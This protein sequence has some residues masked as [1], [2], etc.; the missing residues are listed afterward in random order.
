M[1][2]PY[3][4][5]SRR[6][7]GPS[8]LL[9]QP[10]AILEVKFPARH[11]KLWLATLEKEARRLQRRVGWRHERA[12]VRDQGPSQMLATSAPLDGLMPATYLN[13]A[14]LERTLAL[15]DG[16]EA[17]TLE[18]QTDDLLARIARRAEPRLIALTRAAELHQVPWMLGD[19]D[20]SLGYGAH[21]IRYP[22]D[23][24]PLPDAVDWAHLKTRPKIALITGTNGKTTTTRLL[25]RMLREAGQMAG[26]CSTDYVQ[27][28]EEVVS[29]DD[30]SGPTGARMVLRDPRVT[31]AALE[32]ARGGMLRR[33]L[34]VREADVAVVLNIADDHL[35]D[36]GIY[37]LNQLAEAK[38]L[39]RKGLKRYAPLILNAGSTPL[40]R[41]AKK[42]DQRLRWFGIERPAAALMQ[43]CKRTVYVADDQLVE[44]HEGRIQPLLAVTDIAIGF[45]GAA[46]H[47]L[48]NAAAATLAA[49]E[50]GIERAAIVRTLQNFGRAPT[51]NPGRA[52]LFTIRG[53]RVIADY[54]HNPDGFDAMLKLV[55]AMPHQRLLLMIGQAGDRTDEDIRA[56]ADRAAAGQPARVAIKALSRMLRG[57]EAGAVPA[58]LEQQLLSQGIPA[59]RISHHATDAEAMDT[60]L[61]ELEPGD[62]ALLFIHED[63][64]ALL[65][66]LAERA[67]TD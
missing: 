63:A 42:L 30:Y 62:L 54:G 45:D 32:V 14:A 38:L 12:V 8:L 48:E 21:A 53:A 60:L 17:P 44:E 34:S 37:T 46:R 1:S 33:G 7:T 22:D 11:K 51:D 6:L 10:G 35:G 16:H 52:N 3:L 2:L 43:A 25:A 47:N 15:H 23:E 26:F 27:I 65:A 64:P 9:D 31:A 28:G 19:G 58:L 39:I 55:R 66:R 67:A 56:L 41:E 18:A 40:Q 29:R 59:E 5:D 61:A 50:L 4:L 57:R 49:L 24:L 36:S 20:L 13:E